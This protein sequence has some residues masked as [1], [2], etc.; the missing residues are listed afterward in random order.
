ML[1]NKINHQLISNY[2]CLTSK[3]IAGKTESA[4]DQ[5]TEL[6]PMKQLGSKIIE[7]ETPWWLKIA[8]S[9]EHDPTFEAATQLGQEWH[10]YAE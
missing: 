1:Y 3:I 2:D 8:G 7:K 6:A 9:C 5:E 10:N 4:S